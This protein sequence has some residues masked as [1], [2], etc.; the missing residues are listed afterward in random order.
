MST[1]TRT[2]SWVSPEQYLT[3]ENDHPGNSRH[4]YVDGVIYAMTGASR[5]HN[6]VVSKLALRLGVHLENT[7]CIVFQS[8]MKVCIQR[9]DNVRFYYPDIQVSCEEEMDAYYNIAPSL[10]VEVLSESTARKDRTE[11]LMAYQMI[12]SLQEYVI[13]SQDTPA[14]DIHRKRR[15]WQRE[16]FMDG[17]I[18]TLESVKLDIAVDDLYEFLFN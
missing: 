10:I 5:G 4:E 11:K 1:A 13:C 18:F 8:D 7:P 3:N 16:R 6:R 9:Q 15:N 14:V 2:A 12:Q 17:Q